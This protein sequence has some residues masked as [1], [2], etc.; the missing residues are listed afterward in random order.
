MTSLKVLV[1][2]FAVGVIF[3]CGFGVGV[4][5]DATKVAFPSDYA[6][7]IK[8]LVVDKQPEKQVREVYAPPE[9]VAAARKGD[10]MPD[11]TAITLVRY[12]AK[13]DAQGVPV[14]D[15]TGRL[16]KG[17][18]LGI[19]VMQKGKGW[20]AEYPEDL[21][22]G[23]WEYRAFKADQSPNDQAKLAGCFQCHK[24]QAQE[25]FIYAY[26]SLKAAAE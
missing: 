14:K 25:D 19:N 16:I 1:S 10:A 24:A 12:S 7:G 8:W 26:D 15:E 21:R 23:E 2:G 4:R 22:N 9:A 13:L 17:E 6:K 3:C 5:A 18:V 11:G 20:G